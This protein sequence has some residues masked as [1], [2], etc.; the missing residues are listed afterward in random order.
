MISLRV[1]LSFCL[2]FYQ[3]QPGYAYRKTKRIC[4]QQFEI[5][6]V[7]KHTAFYGEITGYNWAYLQNLIR[8]KK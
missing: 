8:K 2:N 3:F 4:G 6:V 1:L 5:V 7:L